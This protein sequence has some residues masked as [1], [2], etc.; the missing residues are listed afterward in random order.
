MKRFHGKLHFN[1]SKGDLVQLRFILD[2]AVLIAPDISAIDLSLRDD[3]EFYALTVPAGTLEQRRPG[4]YFYPSTGGLP[5]VR[6]LKLT[7]RPGKAAKLS[8]KVEGLD[9]S[10]VDR[11]DGLIE[12][13]LE[14]AD[15]C[16][17]LGRTW[18]ARGKNLRTKF[19]NR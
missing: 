8:L 17:A 4:R 15:Y 7:Q 5:G 13:L 10:T 2:P 6:K 16:P 9:L 3:A 19:K 11:E 12:A 1:A 18:V 14:H